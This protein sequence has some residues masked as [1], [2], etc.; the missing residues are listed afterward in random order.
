MQKWPSQGVVVA[1]QNQG[2]VYGVH[3]HLGIV[4][5]PKAAP[6]MVVNLVH[7]EHDPNH[8]NEAKDYAL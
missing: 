6:R 3:I 5:Q 2:N 1:V 7:W 8:W 4:L